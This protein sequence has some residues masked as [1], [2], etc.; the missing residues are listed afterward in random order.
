MIDVSEN[1]DNGLGIQAFAG[2]KP[3]LDFTGI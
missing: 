3:V 1:C 2:F